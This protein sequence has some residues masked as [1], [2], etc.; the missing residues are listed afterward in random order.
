MTNS[1]DSV[2]RINGVVLVHYM[3]CILWNPAMMLHPMYSAISLYHSSFFWYSTYMTFLSIL[4][5]PDALSLTHR[6]CQITEERDRYIDSDDIDIDCSARLALHCSVALWCD[7]VVWHYDETLQCCTMMW[8]FSAAPWCDTAVWH[9]AVTVHC[10][11]VMRHCSVRPWC[12]VL[13]WHC[14][15]TL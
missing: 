7:I 15:V 13:V 5:R 2:E 6:Q 1:V 9:C 11:T 10:Y 12:D 8:H 4:T 14:C 3:W